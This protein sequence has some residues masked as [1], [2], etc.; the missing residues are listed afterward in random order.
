MALIDC[1]ACNK[2][3]SGKAAVCPHC[4]FAVG[5]ADA[6]DILRKAR[7]NKFKKKQSLMTQSMVAMLMFIV[8]FAVIFWGEP[9]YNS[10]QQYLGI[11]G[12]VLGFTWYVINRLRLILL[13]R[14]D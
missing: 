2:K 5:N 7:Y 12:C 8:G 13:K 1:P 9:E 4:S 11:G 3:I 6:E 10:V 14:S